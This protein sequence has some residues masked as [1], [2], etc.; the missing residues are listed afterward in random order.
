MKIRFWGVRGSFAMTGR[1]V[2]RYGG[3]TS[4]VEVQ[5]DTGKRLLIDLGTA[6]PSLPNS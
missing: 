1:D 3:N 5:S 2:L 6:Q 4:S